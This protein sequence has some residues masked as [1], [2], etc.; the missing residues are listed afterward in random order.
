MEEVNISQFGKHIFI[1]V[2]ILVEKTPLNSTTLLFS[3][4]N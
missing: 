4:N 1:N 2:N 3:Q